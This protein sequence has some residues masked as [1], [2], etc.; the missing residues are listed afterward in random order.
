MVKKSN[1]G[2][3]KE[4]TVTPCIL[5]QNNFR[6]LTETPN[7]LKLNQDKN[8]NLSILGAPIKSLGGDKKQVFDNIYEFTPQIRKALSRSSYTGKSMK[9]EVD[10][11]TLYSFLADVGY[12]GIGD[13]KTNQFFFLLDFLNNLE[14]LKKKSLLIYKEKE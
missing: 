14:I 9:N 3:N 6:S 4:T 2:N 12:N 13:E 10:Q 5:L 11:R 8:G 7:S 1:S